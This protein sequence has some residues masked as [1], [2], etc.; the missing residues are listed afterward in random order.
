LASAFLLFT[1]PPVVSNLLFG[2]ALGDAFADLLSIT[3]LFSSLLHLHPTLRLIRDTFFSD[4]T[5]ST[6]IEG[7]ALFFNGAI[8]GDVTGKLVQQTKQGDGT[9]QI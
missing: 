4:V 6:N 5:K 1:A 8:G 9:T 2:D 7:D 3:F